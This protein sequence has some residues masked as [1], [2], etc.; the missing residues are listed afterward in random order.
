M[1]ARPSIMRVRKINSFKRTSQSNLNENDKEYFNKEKTDTDRKIQVLDRLYKW[2]KH[3]EN[4][5]TSSP[6]PSP[7]QTQSATPWTRT[8]NSTALTFGQCG[9]PL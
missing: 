5:E 7:T 9:N 4:G 6:E 1:E 3:K 2:K 8:A